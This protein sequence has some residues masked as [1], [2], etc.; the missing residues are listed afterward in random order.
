MKAK[1]LLLA[2]V[3]MIFLCIPVLAA[4]EQGG[5]TTSEEQRGQLA[6]Q[7]S[8]E[9]N[10]EAAV[11]GETGKPAAAAAGGQEAGPPAAPAE[12]YKFEASAVLPKYGRFSTDS[13]R[14]EPSTRPT[15]TTS[16]SRGH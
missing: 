16:T 8:Q 10:G 1:S 6:A 13:T 12:Q 4:E 9:K 15:S 5:Q 3:W 7:S 14:V 2:F 11:P